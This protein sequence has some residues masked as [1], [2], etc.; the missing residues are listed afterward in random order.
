MG[1]VVQFVPRA[2]S[3]A[4]ANLAE[5][6]R[7]AKEE[8]TAFGGYDGWNSDTWRHN[9][10]VVVFATKTAP[11][12]SYSFTPLAEPFNEFAKAYV[13]YSYSHKPVKNMATTVQALRCMEAA[14]L[15]VCGRAE[16]A[17]LSVAM[18][19]VSAAKCREFYSSAEVQ[20]NTGRKLQAILDFV[21]EKYLVSSLPAWKSP[22]KKP[23][24][25]T[26]DLGEFGQAHR[27]KKLPSNEAM[28]AV[29]D[30]FAQA[31]DP[32]N[33]FFSSIL[34][35]LM[36]TPSRI[37]EVLKLPVDCIQWESDEQGVLQMYLR[38]GRLRAKVR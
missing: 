16:I 36:A 4:S 14:L 28:L 38:W 23:A 20:C 30:L 5:F 31:D 34:I 6:I 10:T 18:M 3:D 35:L 15:D 1:D 25:L 17:M 12:D 2:E 24:I 33:M 13:R 32:E 29:A 26:E 19:D 9:G 27:A 22:F 11:L 37:S 8:L 21:R 7:L